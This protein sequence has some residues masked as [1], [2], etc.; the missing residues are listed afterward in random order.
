MSD[1]PVLEPD[2]R[3]K[4]ALSELQFLIL[5]RYPEAALSVLWGDDPDGFYL[6]ATV[7][8]DDVDEV[9]DVVRDRLFEMQVE[10]EL[11]IYVIPLEPTNRVL[12]ALRSP[13]P[14]PRIY[15]TKD[16]AGLKTRKRR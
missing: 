12:K 14:S 7:D 11:P 9:L 5:Q 8:I 16:I 4:A 1:Q 6:G 2:G 10:D 15:T 3:V 13:Q